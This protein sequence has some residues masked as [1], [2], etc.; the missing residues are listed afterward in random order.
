MHNL[1]LIKLSASGSLSPRLW[2]DWRT[3]SDENVGGLQFKM[4]STEFAP[5]MNADK[6]YS[7]GKSESKSSIARVDLV[8][9]Y[10]SKITKV[11]LRQPPDVTRRAQPVTSLTFLISAYSIAADTKVGKLRRRPLQTK[12][13]RLRSRYRVSNK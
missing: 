4:T 8:S 9:A 5:R 6:V 10:A 3:H 12:M 7:G 2:L 11:A 13:S 1:A